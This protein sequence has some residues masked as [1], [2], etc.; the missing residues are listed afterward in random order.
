MAESSY[1]IVRRG[2]PGTGCVA[3][4]EG[5]IILTPTATLGVNAVLG[6]AT[7][8]SLMGIAWH[9]VEMATL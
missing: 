5:G 3:N 2:A 8:T 4:I 6:T 7:G 9:E 1:G